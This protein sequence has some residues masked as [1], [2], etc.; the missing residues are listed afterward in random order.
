MSSYSALVLC[1]WSSRPAVAWGTSRR[2]TRNSLRYRDRQR[3]RWQLKV[4]RLTVCESKRLFAS[5]TRKETHHVYHYHVATCGL[6]TAQASYQWASEAFLLCYRLCR[7][8]DCHAAPGA[9][10]ECPG[11]AALHCSTSRALW[12][13]TAALLLCWGTGCHCGA[14]PG[15]LDGDR[16]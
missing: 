11:P 1:C 5:L 7:I 10:S 9:G 15:R 16:G 14:D 13:I 8:L 6:L 12:P 2:R 3:R 4:S